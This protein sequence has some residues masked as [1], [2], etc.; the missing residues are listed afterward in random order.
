ML[1]HLIG[2]GSSKTPPE[3]SRIYSGLILDTAFDLDEEVRVT[4][5]D[6]DN[7]FVTHGPC[8]WQPRGDLMPTEDDECVVIFDE[9]GEPWIAVWWPI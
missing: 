7:R 1:E 9:N 5:Q 8:K 4:I 2:E 6:I 3:S